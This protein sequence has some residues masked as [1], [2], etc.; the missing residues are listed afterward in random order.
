MAICVWN[1]VEISADR[2]IKKRRAES[3]GGTFF[4][5]AHQRLSFT[6]DQK[7]N[8]SPAK[9]FSGQPHLN[10]LEPSTFNCLQ[11]PDSYAAAS[12]LSSTPKRRQLLH[13]HEQGT[14][15][16]HPGAPGPYISAPIRAYIR[17]T[18]P[19]PLIQHHIAHHRIT[20]PTTRQQCSQ[21]NRRPSPPLGL[22]KEPSYRTAHP[23]PRLRQEPA[24]VPRRP[25]WALYHGPYSRVP[26]SRPGRRPDSSP[27][28]H[29]WCFAR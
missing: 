16:L 26:L 18:H 29:A 11:S 27:V 8:R 25:T 12:K 23:Y 15:P 20:K 17:P 21:P 3:P 24:A 7:K 28:P 19:Q 6:Q 2:L 22:Q 1:Q 4:L 5:W 10:F 13:H 14:L 9:C